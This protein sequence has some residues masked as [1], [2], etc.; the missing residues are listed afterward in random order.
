[1]HLYVY[2]IHHVVNKPEKWICKNQS[3]SVYH[4]S[5]YGPT[6]GGHDF[7]LCNGCNTNNSSYSNLGHSY[8]APRDNNKLAG[9]YNF[10]VSDDD[11]FQIIKR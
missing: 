7:Y 8:N 11:V 4:Y 10:K 6:F 3:Y 2:Y 9:S 1:M 5:S